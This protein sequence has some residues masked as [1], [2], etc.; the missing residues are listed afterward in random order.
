[1]RLRLEMPQ[2]EAFSYQQGSQLPA[3]ASQV[4][5]SDC[6]DSDSE[7]EI[8]PWEEDSQLLSGSGQQLSVG[9]QEWAAELNASTRAHDE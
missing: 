7:T 4:P 8:P 1:V 2:S 9:E 5:F 3:E 6:T